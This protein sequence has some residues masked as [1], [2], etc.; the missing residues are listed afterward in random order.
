MEHYPEFVAY[1]E[2]FLELSR[3]W[4]SDPE[5]K[6]LTLTPDFSADAQRKWFES[7]PQRTDY[8]IRGIRYNGVPA[9]ACGLKNISRNQA[10]YW[11]YI[12]EKEY[13]GK[14]IGHFILDFIFAESEK[15][16]IPEIMLRVWNEN[17]RAI[18]LYEKYGFS[19]YHEE[20]DVVFMKKAVIAPPFYIRRYTNVDAVQW[21][22]FIK[23]SRNGS[24]LFDRNYMDY[25]ADRFEDFSLMVFDAKHNLTAVIPANKKNSILFTHQGL[26]FGGIITQASSTAKDFLQMG[27][28]MNDFLRKEGFTKLVYKKIPYIYGGQPTDEDRYFLFRNKAVLTASNI[29][30]TIDLREAFAYK[31]SRKNAVNKAQKQG[32]ELHK[33]LHW[34]EFWN[35][36]DENLK[37]KY[38]AS[39]VH[40]LDEILRLHALFPENIHL[41][42]ASLN[43]ECVGGIVLYESDMVAHAQYISLNEAGR[44]CCALDFILDQLIRREFR[45]KK[46]FD[47][48]S[49][50]EDNGHYL[51][52]ALIFQKEGFGGRGVCYEIFEYEL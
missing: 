20:E 26:T 23:S 13:W 42:T 3:L 45:H 24:F 38:G 28:I 48:G 51:N 29:S 47:L 7:L 22:A 25:H 31:R 11:G 18:R 41:Y 52:E 19:K 9:G 50:T 44:K 5:V 6:K 21:N 39:P 12:G 15:M 40:S 49:S 2:R 27:A 30:T 14:G 33:N 46:Y 8:F 16:K 36:L 10:E 4:L 35:I 32:L 37:Q 34:E 43:G 1:D 17:H